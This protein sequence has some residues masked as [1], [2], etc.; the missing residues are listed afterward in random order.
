MYHVM[1]IIDLLLGV[2]CGILAT[3]MI[4][5]NPTGG[6]FL[7]VMAFVIALSGVGLSGVG[8][9]LVSK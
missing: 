7:N 9:Y 3:L 1:G 5:S 8:L 6:V 2:M 4:I